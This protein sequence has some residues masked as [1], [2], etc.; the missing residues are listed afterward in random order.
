M[1]IDHYSFIQNSKFI[2]SKFK[3]HSFKIHSF[4]IQNSLIQ[5]SFI[6]YRVLIIGVFGKAYYF[7]LGTGQILILF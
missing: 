3:I 2:H 5:N 4:K 7:D 6:H 1:F